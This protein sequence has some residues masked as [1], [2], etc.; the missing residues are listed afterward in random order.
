MDK[1]FNRVRNTNRWLTLPVYIIISVVF[2]LEL[3]LCKFFPQFMLDR[4][5]FAVPLLFTCL[6]HRKASYCS[7]KWC[8][9]FHNIELQNWMWHK[10]CRWWA[11]VDEWGEVLRISL[12]VFKI[13]DYCIFCF[14]N[15]RCVSQAFVNWIETF[16]LLRSCETTFQYRN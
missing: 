4:V 9:A 7:V 12:T 16:S 2:K 1:L 8:W 6:E 5:I 14:E 10:I 15:C 11:V 13:I 3:T